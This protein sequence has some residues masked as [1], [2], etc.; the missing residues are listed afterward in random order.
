MIFENFGGH[1]NAKEYA[2]KKLKSIL[3]RLESSSNR[4]SLVVR[5]K[6]LKNK[7]DAREGRYEITSIFKA[8]GMKPLAVS[9]R[10]S[11]IFTAI[12]SSIEVLKKR[13]QRKSEMTERSRK[14]VGKTL[15]PVKDYIRDS[16]IEE[17]PST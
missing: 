15:R 7:H 10:G 9:K 12:D 1:K 14:T 2:E 8:D 13:I 16:S 17:L 6:E 5:L 11:S 4:R 3:S